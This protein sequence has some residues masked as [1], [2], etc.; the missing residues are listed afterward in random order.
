MTSKSSKQPQ[1]N[2]ARLKESHKDLEAKL[3]GTT[4]R[5]N[6]A[7]TNLA[8]IQ[9]DESNYLNRREKE[10]SD[11]IDVLLNIQNRIIQESTN[12]SEHMEKATKE[13]VK[14]SDTLDSAIAGFKIHAEN[15][16]KKRQKI[17]SEMAEKM[18]RLSLQEQQMI[19][20]ANALRKA[21]QL[22]EH[23]SKKIQT[24]PF[25]P[26]ITKNLPSV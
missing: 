24:F 18:N 4:R 17:E 15:W 6:E 16:E 20:A 21:Q 19:E 13:A 5:L 26:V 9:Q 14:L 22:I 23:N 25:N 7:R 2:E 3:I 1:D 10:E 11:R 12:L 8:K